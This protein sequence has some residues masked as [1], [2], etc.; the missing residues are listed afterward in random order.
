M[1]IVIFENYDDR[2]IAGFVSTS[3]KS[4]QIYLTNKAV[5]VCPQKRKIFLIVGNVC[6]VIFFTNVLYVLGKS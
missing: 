2:N 5:V 1:G 6:W 4:V 3:I